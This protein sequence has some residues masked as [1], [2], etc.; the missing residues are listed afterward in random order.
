MKTTRSKILV[1]T[2]LSVA[3]L[4]GL[5]ACSSNQTRRVDYGAQPAQSMPAG[6]RTLEYGRVEDIQIAGGG[7]G[8]TGGGA[9]IG[10]IVGGVA[11]HQMGG[12]S[13]ARDAAT[14][15]GAVLGA[16]VGNE[17]ERN[18]RGGNAQYSIVR[19]RLENGQLLTME[20]APNVDLRPGDRVRVY[21]RRGIAR[22]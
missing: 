7:G 16:I 12:S 9:V 15:G 18:Q 14:V 11:G 4:I 10:G 6:Y 8:T 21:D 2:L 20:Q 17:I 1:T 19:V 3:T 13:R 5:S 22:Y